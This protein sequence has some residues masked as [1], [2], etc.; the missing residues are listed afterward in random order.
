MENNYIYY[1]LLAGWCADAAGGR[2]EFER[3]RFTEKE[4]DD[5]MHFVGPKT[6]GINDGQITDDSEMEIALLAGIV[7]GKN[8]EYFPIIRI[9]EEYITWYKTSPFD[10]GK[11]ISFSLT[12]ATGVMDM[13]NNA[14][15]YSEESESN[16][17]MMRCIPAVVFSL[18]TSLEKIFELAEAEASL[19]HYS[20]VVQL[21]TAIYSY[22]ISRILANRLDKSEVDVNKLINLIKQL[23][24][25]EKKVHE[26]YNEGMNLENL[27]NYDSIKNEGHVKHAFTFFVYYLKNID[28]YTY[29]SAI[30]EVLKCGGDTD[31]NAKIV[32]NLFGAY[33][34]D[35][36]PKYM[37]EP[38]LAFDCTQ[39]PTKRY[40]RPKEYSVKYGIEL[41][42]EVYKKYT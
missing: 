6:T 31:T 2:L 14:Y 21:S 38:V 15:R 7:K 24:L 13:V 40:R 11:T 16:G 26:W 8:D 28:K 29:T 36:V 35:C 9:A 25:K 23:S 33:Y 32:G 18:Y 3:R 37:S 1:T 22:T 5:A 39:S 10:K 34:G 19:T 42:N 17:S 30:T 41:A 12:N 20:S 4:V 27:D